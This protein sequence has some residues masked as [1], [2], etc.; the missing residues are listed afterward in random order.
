MNLDLLD[1]PLNM[2]AALMQIAIV[3]FCF[4]WGKEERMMNAD[5][6]EVQ[7]RFSLQVLNHLCLFNT[8]KKDC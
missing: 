2:A 8:S 6:V 3:K 4:K 7:F 1:Q 5:L